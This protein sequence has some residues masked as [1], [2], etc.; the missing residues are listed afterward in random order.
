MKVVFEKICK[1]CW[2]QILLS[3]WLSL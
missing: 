1:T 2:I 3:L